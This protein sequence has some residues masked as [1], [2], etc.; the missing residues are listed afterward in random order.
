MNLW[1]LF[2]TKILVF[3]Q[4]LYL[5]YLLIPSYAYL[6][7]AATRFQRVRKPM[8]MFLLLSGFVCGLMIVSFGPNMGKVL[9]PLMLLA[10]PLFPL[11]NLF[12]ALRQTNASIKW[13]WFVASL[14][15]LVLSLSWT[16]WFV[17]LANS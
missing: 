3:E 15:S 12:T 14:A 8:L 7:Y 1:H 5:P 11:F 4:I 10:S 6:I 2:P 13:I 16:V 9:P 17:A